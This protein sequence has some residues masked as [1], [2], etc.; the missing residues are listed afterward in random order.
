M[1]IAKSVAGNGGNT[2]RYGSNGTLWCNPCNIK[3]NVHMLPPWFDASKWNTQRC[4]E[5]SNSVQRNNPKTICHTMNPYSQTFQWQMKTKSE[6][7]CNRNNEEKERGKKR[8][9]YTYIA[10][11]F[12]VCI[13]DANDCQT[14]YNWNPKS[15]N[16]PPRCFCKHF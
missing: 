3:W 15:R 8:M 9:F 1:R 2:N 12:V 4:S 10:V 6:I 5:Y 11:L 16:K 14:N 7:H 13:I